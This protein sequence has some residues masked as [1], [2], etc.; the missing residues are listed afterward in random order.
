M[1]KNLSIKL[2]LYA[3]FGVVMLLAGMLAVIALYSI[4]TINGDISAIVNDRWPKTVQ[5]NEIIDKIN[6]A[7][8]AIRNAVI[9]EDAQLIQQELDRIPEASK[10]ITENI[11]KLEEKASSD[12]E[13]Q[14]L[15][16]LKEKRAAYR[17]DLAKA[18]QLIEAGK[19]KDAGLYLVTN[20]RK[21]QSAYLAASANLIKYQSELMDESGKDAAGKANKAQIFIIVLGFT[22]TVLSISA[23]ILIIRSITAPLSEGVDVANRLAEGD[24]TASI[25]IRHSDEIGALMTA[26]SNMVINLRELIGKIK[27]AAENMASGSEQ[28]SASA[29]E[30]SRGMDGQASRSSQ[31]ATA[32][33]EMSQTVIDV[34]KNTSNIAQISSQAFDQAKDGEGIVKRSV[35]EVQAIA[36]TVSESAQVMQRL[37]E[38]SKQI[39][40]IVGVINDIADQTNLLALNAAIE[41]ARAGEQ[42][43]GFAVVADE[44]RKLAERTTQATSQI[45]SMISSIQTEVEHAG[46]TM[47][48]ATSR[49]ESGVEFSRKAGHSLGNIVGS[50]N[51]LQ[52]MVQHIASATEE[53]STVSETI[54]ADIQSIAEGSKEISAGSG[55]IAKASSDLAKLATE[56][57]SVVGQFKV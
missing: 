7:A 57:H 25:T 20:L 30:I 17:D 36:S 18:T 14:L 32:T 49:V 43:R 37:G 47:K 12:K 3:G 55:Q 2:R 6:V 10:V 22:A 44:V 34:A 13:K 4:Y 48:N 16:D 15:N 19:K 53:M 51:N 45:N 42:G 23:S 39:G 21:T 31:I 9:L 5:A 24:L 26:M 40:N 54:S 52:S 11:D 27:Y 29:E 50:V 28:L 38:S 46:V 33:E 8:R 41:A 1:L 35:D 56:L